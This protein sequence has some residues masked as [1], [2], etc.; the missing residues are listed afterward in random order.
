MYLVFQKCFL[1]SPRSCLEDRDSSVLRSGEEVTSVVEL[2][3]VDCTVSV[4]QGTV[5]GAF[6]KVENLKNKKISLNP[7]CCG[8][9]R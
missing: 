4:S 9:A 8:L 5:L 2:H 7:W 1:N 3:G 6:A